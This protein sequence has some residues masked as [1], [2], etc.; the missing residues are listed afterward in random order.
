MTSIYFI[1]HGQASF[2]SDNYDQL[3]DLGFEQ[4][5]HLGLSLAS[6]VSPLKVFAGTMLR[7]KQTADSALESL[8]DLDCSAINYD[9]VWNEFDH[10]NV[11]AGLDQSWAKP[12]EF[13]K[14]IIASDNPERVFI[15]TFDKAVRRWVN[16]QYDDDYNESW[17]D[18][19][20]RVLT[21]FEHLVDSTEPNSDVVV[22]TSGGV[23][24]CIAQQLLDIADENLLS[25]NRNLVN[26][27]ITKIKL[28]RFGNQLAT[29]NDHSHFDNNDY[30]HMITYK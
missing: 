30:R 3:S 27:G 24:S 19:K 29:L 11:I 28:T 7:H 9:S 4:A 8:A 2:S 22:F 23:I 1:R 12:S 15:E 25:M 17:T 13:R 16:G 5:R 26:C 6:R 18:F 20:T 14:F 21:A 10:Q